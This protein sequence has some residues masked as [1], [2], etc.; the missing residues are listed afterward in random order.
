MRTWGLHESTL[1]SP[2]KFREAMSDIRVIAL[3][4]KNECRAVTQ[5]E[6]E[7]FEK[8]WS[9]DSRLVRNL[10]GVCGILGIDQPASNIIKGLSGAIKPAIPTPRIIGSSKSPLINL[11]VA[12]IRIYQ[13]DRSDRIDICWE[14]KKPG[15]WVEVPNK[16]MGI[17]WINRRRSYGTVLITSDLEVSSE[18]LDYDLVVWRGWCLILAKSPINELREVLGMNEHFGHW[19]AILLRNGEIPIEELPLLKQHLAAAKG[20][21]GEELLGRLVLPFERRFGDIS[22]VGPRHDHIFAKDW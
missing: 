14:K 17:D 6:L 20:P 22:R 7:S 8:V 3:E 13:E 19:L 15:R 12:K 5:K 9:V 18:C 11:E 10:E 21:A 1:S 4:D 2:Q 16:S